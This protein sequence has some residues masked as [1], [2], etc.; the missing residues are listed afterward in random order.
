MQKYIYLFKKGTL[1]SYV[2][3]LTLSRVWYYIADRPPL[4]L[5]GV[6]LGDRNN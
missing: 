3:S 6:S 1:T 4:V 2:Q 5:V